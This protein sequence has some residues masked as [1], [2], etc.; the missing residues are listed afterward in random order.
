MLPGPLAAATYAAVK[1]VGYAGFA[2]GL[3]RILARNISVWKFGLAKTAI[4]LAF[5]LIYIFVIVGSS[6][7]GALTETQI[8][9]GAV[10]IRF[11]AWS[12]TL[13]LFYGFRD[14]PVTICLVLVTGVMWSY[15]LDG[16]MTILYRLPGM[17]MPFC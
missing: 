17:T 16:V 9:I 3:N 4:G 5:G 7:I 14:R 11:I 6:I 1:I 13:A 8:F 12:L 10:P 15:I 2:N